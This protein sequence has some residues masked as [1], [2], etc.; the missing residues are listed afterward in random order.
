MINDLTQLRARIV[1]RL[2]AWASLNIGLAALLFAAGVGPLLRG[3]ATQAAAWGTINAAI[4]LGAAWV[5]RRRATKGDEARSARDVTKDARG[6]RRLLLLN[7]ALDVLYVVAGI[8]VALVPG[9][10][11]ALWRGHGW[12]IALQGAFLFVFDLIHAQSVP[13]GVSLRPFEAF[14]GPEHL[15]FLLEGGQPAAL[16]VHGFPGTPAEMRGLGQALHQAGWTVQ[17]LLLPGFGADLSTL[18]DR[19]YED[20]LGAIEDALHNLRQA[21]APLLLVGYSMGAAL[22]TAVAVRDKVDGLIVLA[23]FVWQDPPLQRCFGWLVRPFLPRYFRP[24]RLFDLSNPQA[25]RFLAKL[26]PQLDLDDLQVQEQL[27]QVEVPLTLF[28]QVRKAG[29]LA[30]QS[31]PRLAVPTL[32]VVG[33]RDELAGVARVQPLLSRIRPAPRYVEVDAAHDLTSPDNAQWPV[34]ETAVTE[35]AA[36]VLRV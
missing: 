18:A 29:Q 2:L 31:A 30:L 16:L 21:H 20:W 27:R 1:R 4:A 17:G 5:E 10:T 11:S 7:T 6:L 36:S 34:V 35:F 23:P 13:L 32:V 3:L 28:D 8:S 19:R 24:F 14:S 22:S 26:M 15:P 12:G 33:K 25:R 9:A